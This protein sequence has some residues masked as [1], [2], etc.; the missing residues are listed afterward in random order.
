MLGTISRVIRYLFDLREEI[1]RSE[2]LKRVVV[3]RSH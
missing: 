3:T 2:K 1:Q